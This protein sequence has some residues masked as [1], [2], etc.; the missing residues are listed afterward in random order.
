MTRKVDLTGRSICVVDDDITVLKAVCMTCE[1]VGA[2]THCFSDA[3]SCLKAL[4][5]GCC[6]LLITDVKM[7]GMNGL[8]L[9]REV[10]RVIPSLPVLLMTGYGDV[11]LAVEALKAG[12]A[13]FI[14]KPLE[15]SSLLSALESAID[16]SHGVSGRAGPVLS[17]VELRVLRLLLAGKTVKEIAS[18]RHRSLRTIEDERARIL[19][20]LGA[21]NVVEL[22]NKVGNVRL[23]DIL[24]EP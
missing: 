3:A 23:P 19:R 13:D 11:P 9:L 18:L 1:Q 16:G 14:E 21:K 20:K 2:D 7:P 22:L 6:D 15:M 8:E 17:K 10:E 12:A 24:K 4:H 5:S